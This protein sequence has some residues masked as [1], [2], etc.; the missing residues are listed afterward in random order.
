MI[1]GPINPN[2]SNPNTQVPS[3]LQQPA[4]FSSGGFNPHFPPP[5]PSPT[6]QPTAVNG[7]S[8]QPS[9]TKT[10]QPEIKAQQSQVP[11]Q[12]A[13]KTQQAGTP[14]KTAHPQTHQ[15]NQGSGTQQIHTAV[16][17]QQ[18]HFQEK[19]QAQA[20]GNTMQF[21][22]LTQN[23]QQPGPQV[24]QHRSTAVK[25]QN[26]Q[27][28][29]KTG[30]TAGIA[31]ILKRG[32]PQPQQNSQTNFGQFNAPFNNQQPYVQGKQQAQMRQ[33]NAHYMAPMG[34]VG[35]IMQQNTIGVMGTYGQN[36]QQS[37]PTQQNNLMPSPQQIAIVGIPIQYRNWNT[38]QPTSMINQGTN[39]PPGINVQQQQQQGGYRQIPVNQQSKFY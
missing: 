14:L 3:F 20:Q 22:D 32:Y 15:N 36:T 27:P 10:T 18:P 35:P 8:A 33:M 12:V 19:Q 31:P 26:P 37:Y 6:H 5:P 16:K 13:K 29:I 38:V 17:S 7:P 39:V 4:P 25:S 23:T 21:I 34:A 30:Q 1:G 9:T 28:Y 24:Q 2:M 11:Q